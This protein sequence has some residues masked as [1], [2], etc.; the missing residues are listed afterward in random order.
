[1]AA[2]PTNESTLMADPGDNDHRV[3][4][5]EQELHDLRAELCALRRGKE[6]A[7][8][9]LRRTQEELRACKAELTAMRQ[10][11]QQSD[12]AT[13]NQRYALLRMGDEHRA[14]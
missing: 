13:T 2:P 6:E 7:L 11:W 10:F 14:K 9:E 5:L 1:M 3:L 12:S 8:D 4:K